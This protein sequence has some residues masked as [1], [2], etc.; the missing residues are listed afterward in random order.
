MSDRERT[1]VV[2]ERLAAGRNGLDERM[3]LRVDLMDRLQR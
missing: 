3:N 2:R 1:S